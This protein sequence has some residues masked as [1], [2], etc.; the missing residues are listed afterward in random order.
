M[1]VGK[2][3]GHLTT[4]SGLFR[5][6]NFFAYLHARSGVHFSVIRHSPPPHASTRSGRN[7]CRETTF[8]LC[9]QATSAKTDE[10]SLRRNTKAASAGVPSAARLDEGPGGPLMVK[11]A[12]RSRSKE[13]EKKEPPRKR[14]AS[15]GFE[16]YLIDVAPEPVLARLK[17]LH[18]WMPRGVEVLGRVFVP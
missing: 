8:R 12:E 5:M 11:D 14:K 2:A 16:G 3:S 13:K 10:G 9:P 17:G 7:P 1:E 6:T 4:P 15:G 18:D